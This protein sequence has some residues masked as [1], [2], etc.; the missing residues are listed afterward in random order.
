MSRKWF[1]G[2]S[3]Y[4]WFCKAIRLKVRSCRTEEL[5]LST[6]LK[7]HEPFQILNTYHINM[8]PFEGPNLLAPVTELMGQKPTLFSR[9]PYP[10]PTYQQI[11]LRRQNPSAVYFV[12]H[13][14]TLN[15]A[16]L[17]VPTGARASSASR[18]RDRD[19]DTRRWRG[20]WAYTVEKC[21]GRWPA[22]CR[23][24]SGLTLAGAV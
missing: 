4:S 3:I 9:R 16:S 5:T 13:R 7:L 6:P 8:L 18:D 15:L 19:F 2:V 10:R 22:L 12:R 14:R 11:L 24:Q 23:R 17:I 20:S 1:A 21:E